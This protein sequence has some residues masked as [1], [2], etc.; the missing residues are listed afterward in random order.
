MRDRFPWFQHSGRG[1][2]GPIAGKRR[3]VRGAMQNEEFHSGALPPPDHDNRSRNF[4]SRPRSNRCRMLH[5]V[6][7]PA[8][9]MVYDR[10]AAFPAYINVTANGLD[11][12]A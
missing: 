6:I 9:T 7:P 11:R 4:G 1:P 10:S 8:E 3:T 2:P 12:V 5:Q